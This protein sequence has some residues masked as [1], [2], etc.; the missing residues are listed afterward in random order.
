M[1]AEEIATENTR[2]FGLVRPDPEPEAVPDERLLKLARQRM[3]AVGDYLNNNGV[4]PGRFILC[5]GEISDQAKAKPGVRI[6]L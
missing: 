1:L 4:D 3:R 2:L 5:D 6:E